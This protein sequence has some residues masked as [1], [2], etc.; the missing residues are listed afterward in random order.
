[1][2]GL[3][4]PLG[5]ATG[6]IAFDVRRVPPSPA[7]ETAVSE[8]VTAALELQ[9][10]LDQQFPPEVAE[11]AG[12]ALAAASALAAAGPEDAPSLVAPLAEAVTA[13]A[14]GLNRLAEPAARLAQAA[15]A[16]PGPEA[17]AEAAAAIREAAATLR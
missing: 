12:R 10:A 14:A 15:S 9:A 6:T 11:A 7:Q 16:P 8:L 3:R 13:L 17:L 5:E 4:D 1:M 2:G